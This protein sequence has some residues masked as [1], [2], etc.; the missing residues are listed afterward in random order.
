MHGLVDY[1]SGNQNDLYSAKQRLES[2]EI[3]PTEPSD[4]KSINVVE[5]MTVGHVGLC[6]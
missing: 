4:R 1:I 5:F 3:L 6:M 2:S